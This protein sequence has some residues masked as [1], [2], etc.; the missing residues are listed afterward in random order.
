MGRTFRICAGGMLCTCGLEVERVCVEVVGRVTVAKRDWDPLSLLPLLVLVEVLLVIVGLAW[1]PP[2]LLLVVVLPVPG[3]L[4]AEDPGGFPPALICTW[5]SAW[6]GAALTTA[7]IKRATCIWAL[8]AGKR[9]N[10]VVEFDR[11][12]LK[13]TIEAIAQLWWKLC[14]VLLFSNEWV[15]NHAKIVNQLVQKVTF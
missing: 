5:I 7:W 1:G 6:I 13:G 4:G 9:R 10:N 2:L 8:L 11:C 12:L 14:L 15:W 3:V